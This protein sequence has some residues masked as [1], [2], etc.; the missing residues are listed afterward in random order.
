MKSPTSLPA[1]PALVSVL[2]SALV[3]AL[4]PAA[5]LMPSPAHAAGHQSEHAI[6][7]ELDPQDML[8]GLE[9]QRAQA[10]LRRDI[11]TLRHLMDR[12]YHHVDSRGRVRSKTELLTALER[13]D[14]RF[15][16]YDIESAEVQLLDE[17][18]VALVTG[19]FS[20]LQAGARARPF[21]GRY[22]HVWVRQPDGWKNTYHQVTAIRPAQ[23]AR[24]R[25]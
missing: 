16:S 3:S 4:L 25:D 19:T 21:R 18:G 15:R 8:A 9:R 22:V 12:Q 14:L 17:G 13:E 6:A 7:A 11:A 2:V 5:L 1:P 10:I 24:R 20:S 23:G